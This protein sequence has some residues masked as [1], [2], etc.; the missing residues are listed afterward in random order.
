MVEGRIASSW[1]ASVPLQKL[2]VAHLE[3]FYAD[4]TDVR[5]ATI[6]VYHTLIRCALGRAVK[7]RMLVRNVAKEDVER[8]TVAESATPR[9]HCWTAAEARTFLQTVAGEPAQTSAFFTLAL[10]CGARKME[11]LGLQWSHVDL[12]AARLT[13]AH[14]L[15][16]MDKD[17]RPTFAPTKTGR[18][19]VVTLSAPTVARLRE[20]KRQ[21]AALKLRNRT[22]YVDAGLVFAK[23]QANLQTPTSKLG[24]PLPRERLTGYEIKR[25]AKIAGVRRIVFHGLRHTS[26]TLLLQNGEPVHVVSQ[27]L[28][29]K[30]PAMT[31]DVYAHALPDQQTGAAE[32]LGTLLHG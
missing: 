1:L 15:A 13:I 20:H 6:A 11:L 12:D 7:A 28:G 31:L 23:E 3:R 22:A 4:Q 30:K 14:Q 29:H 25:L 9:E 26:A 32:R 24:Q 18:T 19:R 17:G 10:D 2:E 21:Q 5:P 8:P 27:R 16:G